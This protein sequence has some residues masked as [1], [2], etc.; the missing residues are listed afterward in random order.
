MSPRGG[1]G[2][3]Y[4]SVGCPYVLLLCPFAL[5]RFAMGKPMDSHDMALPRKGHVVRKGR[6]VAKQNRSTMYEVVTDLRNLR[7]GGGGGGALYY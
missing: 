6:M 2:Y 3:I 4:I 5:Y 1:G 7:G